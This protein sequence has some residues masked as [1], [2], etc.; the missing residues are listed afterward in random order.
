MTR[1]LIYLSGPMTGYPRLNRAMFSCA[2]EWVRAQG[3]QP[4]DPADLNPGRRAWWLCMLV[5]LWYLRLADRLLLLPGWQR[6]RGAR[7]EVAAAV[8][9]GLPIDVWRQGDPYAS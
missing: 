5:D 3:G 2:G 8:V 7:L 4:I 9:L 1:P 6:S